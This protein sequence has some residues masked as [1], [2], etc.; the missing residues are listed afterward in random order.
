LRIA[1]LNNSAL[2]AGHIN[3]LKKIGDVI[4]Y[5]NTTGE[6]E[7]ISRLDGIE[8]A[9][10]DCVD[11]PFTKK[12]FQKAQALK[13]LCINSTGFEQIDLNAASERRVIISNVPD[14]STDS[15]AEHT[16][17]LMFSLCRQIIES[18]QAM[19]VSP[20]EIDLSEK[21]H[22]KY[23]GRVINGK[24]LGIIGLGKIGC[25]VAELGKGLGMNVLS[26]SRSQKVIQNAKPKSFDDLLMLS[27]FISINATYEPGFKDLFD[28]NAI[29]KLKPE[30]IIVNTARGEFVNEPAIAKALITNKLGGYATDVVGDKT[31]DNPLLNLDKVVLTPHSGFF[32]RESL[33]KLADTIIENVESFVANY[34]KNIIKPKENNNELAK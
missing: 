14:Y 28:E 1:I 11:V 25:R 15:V 8:I 10:A 13:Y 2:T 33:T 26:F 22:N 5:E 6:N 16:I 12:V 4:E 29:S 19:Q 3:R 31:R 17:A 21:E 7:A 23:L 30:C 20:F 27:D 24:T 18:N 34:P 9:I 32:T